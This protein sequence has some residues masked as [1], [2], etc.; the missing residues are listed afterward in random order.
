MRLDVGYVL[1]LKLA[2]FSEDLRLFLD[3]LKDH[4]HHLAAPGRMEENG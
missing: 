1:H 4:K 2:W 3:P